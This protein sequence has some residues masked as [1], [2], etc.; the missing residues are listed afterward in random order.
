MKKSNMTSHLSER[1]I[2]AESLLNVA[3]ERTLRSN[4]FESLT[5]KFLIKQVEKIG[6]A[7]HSF[8]KRQL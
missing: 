8:Y 4:F 7:R 6:K 2:V 5:I 3:C 1:Q